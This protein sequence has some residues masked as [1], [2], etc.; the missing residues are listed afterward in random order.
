MPLLDVSDLLSDPDIA[1]Q[2]FT[3]IRSTVTVG[4]DGQGI[5]TVSTIQA[6]GSVQPAGSQDLMRLPEGDMQTGAIKIRTVFRLTS[7]GADFSKDIV[8]WPA[9]TGARYFVQTVDDWSQFGVG[10]VEALA[11]LADINP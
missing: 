6:I 8:Q 10:Y 3:V 11:T 7:G 2:A 4:M 5:G 9:S 1:G